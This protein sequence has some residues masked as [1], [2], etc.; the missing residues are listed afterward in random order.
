MDFIYV[1]DHG[2]TLQLIWKKKKKTVRDSLL[3]QVVENVFQ[4]SKHFFLELQRCK[5]KDVA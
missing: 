1:F 4:F 2:P 3:N 5:I